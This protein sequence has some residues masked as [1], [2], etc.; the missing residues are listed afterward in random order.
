MVTFW[1]AALALSLLLYVVLDGFDLGIGMLFPLAPSE[2]ARREILASISPVWDGNE[3]WLVV[4]AAV[5]FGA[6]PLVYSIVVSA[7]YLPI[8]LMLVSLILRGVAFEFRYKA[9]PRMRA[10]WDAGFVGGS[11]LATFVQGTT[12]GA[13][14]QELPIEGG[15]FV[16]GPLFWATPLALLCGLG[17]CL[18][19]AMMGA[20]WLVAKT[21]GR[22]RDFGYRI[23][24]WLL[25]ALL[26]FL[27]ASFALSLTRHLQVLHRWIDR[28]VLLVFPAVGLLAAVLMVRAV[29]AR[30]DPWPIV[31]GTLIFGAAFGTLAI[32]F[33][34][35][36]VPFSITIE[37][38]A[39][40]P[41]SLAFLFWGAGVVVLPLTLLYTGA[42][43]FIF[44][45]KVTAAADY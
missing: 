20:S 12:V 34:P 25:G 14:V 33:F 29:R 26:A 19:Y 32:S 18:G 5:L 23:L 16:G 6:F 13:L 3:T 8:L 9:G 11:Y 41:S 27:A 21:E 10:V 38:A 39:A 45:G 15:R 43:Y 4:A 28:P 2:T 44:R 1:A 36:M 31:A 35:Y 37:Q 42:V 22:T 40:P 7:F 30:R 17:L 24:P